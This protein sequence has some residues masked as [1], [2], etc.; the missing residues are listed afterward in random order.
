MLSHKSNIHRSILPK[1]GE[2][3]YLIK[4]T[5]RY[6]YS[7][8]WGKKS[9]WRVVAFPLCDN[10]SPYSIGIHTAYF[11]NLATGEIK[12]YSGFYFQST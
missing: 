9:K 10:V 3:G 7:L 2:V 11:L 12:R 4:G 6:G 8:F 1:L 5:D